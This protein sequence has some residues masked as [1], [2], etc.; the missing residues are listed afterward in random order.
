MTGERESQPSGG[1]LAGQVAVVTGGASGI[2]YGIAEVL[3]SHGVK[4][5]IA[6][7]NQEGAS[8]VATDL[9]SAYG[10]A[11]AGVE[12]DVRDRQSVAEMLSGTK[13]SIGD[14]SILINNAGYCRIVPFVE[15][16]EEMAIDLWRF[17]VLGSMLCSKAVLAGMRRAEFGRIVMIV[18]GGGTGASPL[19]T[20]YQSAKA[21]QTSLARGMALA[22]AS[23]GVTVNCVSPGIVETALWEAVDS[24]YQRVKGI[25]SE[26][27]IRR[28]I[29]ASP[30]LRRIPP[31]EIGDVVAFLC[32]QEARAVAGEV[33][34]IL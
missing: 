15:V 7:I 3:A 25:S 18:S 23:T 5:I 24:D 32:S 30:N 6:D 12:C 21:A 9:S 26:E 34:S 28:R 29:E 33:I 13:E 14:P 22:L 17:H 19:T 16:T 31:Q 20:L 4:V 1:Q 11:Y 10:V 2:G 8:R 27:E